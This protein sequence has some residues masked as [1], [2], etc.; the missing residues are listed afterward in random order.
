MFLRLSY[1]MLFHLS[2]KIHGSVTP[3]RL[4]GDQYKCISQ[5]C[6]F[7]C[8]LQTEFTDTLCRS[9]L[10]IL[11]FPWIGYSSLTES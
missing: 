6:Y 5:W 1:F 3:S 11:Y 8:W 4:A 10:G 2:V 9:C 7:V